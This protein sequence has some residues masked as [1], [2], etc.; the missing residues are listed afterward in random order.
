MARWASGPPMRLP[1]LPLA[2]LGSALL[3]CAS[4]PVRPSGPT[5]IIA[6]DLE[7]TPLDSS[8]WVVTHTGPWPSNSLLVRTP[9]G[10]LILCDTPFDVDST[11]KLLRWMEARFGQRPTIAFNSRF[12]PDALGGNAALREARIPVYGSDLTVL[13]MEDEGPRLRR[14][15]LAAMGAS[16][17]WREI[18]RDAQWVAPDQVFDTDTEL[19]LRFGGESLVVL[20][21]GPGSADDN[22]VVHF[23]RR[24]MLYTG[25]LA[26]G[27]GVLGRTDD[28]NMHTWDAALTRLIA[29]EPE[30]VVPWRGH[31]FDP[32]LLEDT[33][34]LVEDAPR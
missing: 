14:G 6:P 20:H 29:L 18:V 31:R 19:R 12:H 13:A 5:E 11:R 26:T 15:L 25:S 34:E 16:S 32:G 23:P 28:A 24:R 8:A 22:V 10:S 3:G 27:D 4:P 21:P 30:V 7:L 33:L 9:D 1:L 2:L 17:P